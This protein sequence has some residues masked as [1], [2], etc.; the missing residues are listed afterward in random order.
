MPGTARVLRGGVLSAWY[1]CSVEGRG[2]E[3]LVQLEC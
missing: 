2:V 1:S 3:C